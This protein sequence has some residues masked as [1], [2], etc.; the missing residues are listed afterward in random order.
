M[1]KTET[2]HAVNVA[3]FILL[4][5]FVFGFG[6]RY[7]PSIARLKLDNLRAVRD[8]AE[9]ALKALDVALAPYIDIVSVRDGLFAPLAPLATRIRLYAKT[10]HLEPGTMKAIEELVRKLHGERAKAKS[11]NP[12]DDH[13]YISVSQLSFNQRI[14]NFAKLI[15]LLSNQPL[16]NPTEADLTINGLKD[17]L[18][19]LR[20][21]NVNVQDAHILVIDTRDRRNTTLYAPIDGLVDVANDVKSYVHSAFGSKSDEYQ[22]VLWPK[23]GA[24][25][26]NHN[27][28]Q[29]GSGRYSWPQRIRK[30]NAFTLSQFFGTRRFRRIAHW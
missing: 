24:A 1:K 8:A 5:E 25:R 9:A 11:T 20:Q 10:L 19:K 29:R 16:Y 17:L 23:R 15:E 6:A 21:S 3:N 12:E 14:E 7:A 27:R 22:K 30:D 26:Y 13:K 4:F 2:G 28:Q 18:A